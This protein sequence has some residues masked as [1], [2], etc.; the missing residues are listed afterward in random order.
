MKT[1]EIWRQVTGHYYELKLEDGNLVIEATDFSREL[2]PGLVS[3]LKAHKSELLSL[4]RF[5][6]QADVMLLESSRRIAQAWP[7]GFNLDTDYQWRLMEQ[8]LHAAYFTGDLGRV[9]AVIDC[10]EQLALKLFETYGKERA[11]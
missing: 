3:E 2:P 9:Q 5:Q 1:L 11:T 8:D 10:R 4:L 6:E 7:R